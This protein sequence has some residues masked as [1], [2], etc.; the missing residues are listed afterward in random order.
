MTEQTLNLPGIEALEGATIIEP[1]EA[2]IEI[3][4]SSSA[5]QCGM[6]SLAS[7]LVSFLTAQGYKNVQPDYFSLDRL[8]RVTPEHVKEVQQRVIIKVQIP[9]FDLPPES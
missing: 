6:G 8:G 5:R 4:I 2:V 9:Q 7:Q 3:K 1:E